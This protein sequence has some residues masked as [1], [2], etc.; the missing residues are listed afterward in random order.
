MKRKYTGWG[1][2]FGLVSFRFVSFHFISFG[3]VRFGL[4]GG[5]R[6]C[7][8][9]FFSEGAVLYKIQ[10]Y[11]LPGHLGTNIYQHNPL[12]PCWWKGQNYRWVKHPWASSTH[13][14]VREEPENGPGSPEPQK[15]QGQGRNHPENTDNC[16]GMVNTPFVDKSLRF[17]CPG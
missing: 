9:L 10:S 6:W 16:L 7:F 4:V 1:F 2:W 8:F 15:L 3:W 12:S 11:F 14:W 5:W 17:S 13:Q